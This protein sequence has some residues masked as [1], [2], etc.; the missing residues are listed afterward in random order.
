MSRKHRHKLSGIE[1]YEA[2]R[3]MGKLI[4]E[5]PW[6]QLIVMM[7]LL[8]GQF[9]HLESTQDDGCAIAVLC[10]LGQRSGK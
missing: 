10:H 2:F 4:R 1:R 9:S 7:L 3:M 6:Q 8:Q 5:S